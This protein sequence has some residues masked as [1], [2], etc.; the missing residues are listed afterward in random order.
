MWFNKGLL[1]SLLHKFH[2]TVTTLLLRLGVTLTLRVLRS[3][4]HLCTDS[5]PPSE[6]S[7]PAF[8]AGQRLLRTLHCRDLTSDCYRPEPELPQQPPDCPPTV[9][10]ILSPSCLLYQTDCPER[11]FSKCQFPS[12][13]LSV[14]SHFPQCK[15]KIPW[16][17]NQAH[18]K[19]T[20]TYLSNFTPVWPYT[21]CLL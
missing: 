6:P 10:S 2:L 14:T 1:E 7:P 4:A 17:G 9:S 5:P 15:T 21:N 12:E 3:S 13:T 20:I 8:T 11:V 18:H 19:L 16:L